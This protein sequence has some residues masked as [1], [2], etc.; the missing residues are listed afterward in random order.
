MTVYS[1]PIQNVR[2]PK[3][4]LD[5]FAPRAAAEL[6]RRQQEEQ[7]RRSEQRHRAFI[8]TNTDAMWRIE[9]DPPVSTALPER[10][11]LEAIYRNGYIAECNEALARQ[12]G[13]DNPEQIVGWPIKDIALLSN[14]SV[15]NAT[16]HA[17]RSGYRYNTIE[18]T[19]VGVDG[20][21][22]Y[23]LRTQWGI[24]DHGMLRRIWGSTRDLTEL[25]QSEIA[26]DASEQ[27]FSGLLECLPLIVLVVQPNGEVTF[28]N[29]HLTRLTGWRFSDISGK[30]WID[31]MIPVGERARV[32]ATIAAASTNPPRPVH[33]QSPLLGRNGERRWI[34]WDST[35][36]RD[37]DG[38]TAEIAVVG[39][40]ITEFK[41]LEAQFHQTQKLEH[42]GRMAG[43]IAHDFN[44]LLTVIMGHT[45]V[46]LE[47]A[48]PPQ[49]VRDALEQILKAAETGANLTQ[50]LFAFSRHRVLRP[51]VLNPGDLIADDERM[52]RQLVGDRIQVVIR[53]DSSPGF[54]QADAGHLHQIIL[55]LVVNARDA[56]PGGGTLTISTSNADP[57]S[58]EITVAD[59]GTGMTEEVCTHMF[60]P[61]YTTKEQ[62][63][64]TGLGLSTVYGIVQ[65]SG[66][67]IV[68]ETKPESGSTFQIFLPK[69]PPQAGTRQTLRK[70]G[71]APAG[72]ETILLV[73]DQRE[74]RMLAAGILRDLGY[75][76]LEAENPAQALELALHPG[77]DAVQLL[78]AGVTKPGT[79]GSELAD[80]IKTSCRNLRVVFMSGYTGPA[81]G[82]QDIAERGIGWLQKPFT[83]EA[84]AVAVRELLDQL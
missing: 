84:L 51:E 38:I 27:R 55:N 11:Q 21:I 30:D 46:L 32:R 62:G 40:D 74:V 45:G 5:I 36:L 81:G 83:R 44:N 60:E 4:I 57:H 28:W 72:T 65:Q 3:E 50:R 80:T 54:V 73:E 69:V 41:A 61:F 25:K 77:G 18:T 17:I 64:G 78:L 39:C 70:T 52:I 29:D 75:R 20:K 47:T 56:M 19:P 66:G 67:H 23:L 22:R 35:G 42:I 31:L 26:L 33:F 14:P 24:V 71:E 1:K 34:A 12:L 8:T 63:K 68:V 58:V 10:D 13:A 37:A 53:L 76:V 16:I 59:T 49:P 6:E 2:S 9:F 15:R 82:M 7:L 43:G 48:R 79:A